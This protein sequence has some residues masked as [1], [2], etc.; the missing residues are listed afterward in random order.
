MADDDI[1]SRSGST[2]I[3]IAAQDHAVLLK[4]C[5]PNSE[6]RGIDCAAIA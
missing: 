4:P 5:N 2:M 3:Y 1:E 6:S